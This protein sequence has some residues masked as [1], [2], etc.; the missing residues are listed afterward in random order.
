M[1][2]AITLPGSS[3]MHAGQGDAPPSLGGVRVH[4]CVCVRVC[5][6]TI[7]PGTFCLASRHLSTL[8]SLTLCHIVALEMPN[9]LFIRINL[10]N[11]WLLFR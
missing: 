8:K 1:L 10:K 4:V 9:A 11:K 3:F 5:V 2:M 7:K 6:F